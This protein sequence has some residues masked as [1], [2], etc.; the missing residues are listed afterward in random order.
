M[1][2]KLMPRAQ[3]AVARRLGRRRGHRAAV[4]G[5]QV[6]DRPLHR[7]ERVA[8]AFGAAGSLVVV[9][10]WVYYSAQIFL[11][12]A[13]FTWVYAHSHGSAQGQLRPA[14]RSTRCASPKEFRPRSGPRRSRCR[15]MP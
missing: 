11:L 13:E 9:L 10:I 5:R 15:A 14:R 12:G 7:H 1:I 8:S 6:P 3:V 4:H 2:Y